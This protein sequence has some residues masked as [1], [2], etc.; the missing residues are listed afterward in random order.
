MAWS[1][2]FAEI[3][4][5]ENKRVNFDTQLWLLIS[6]VNLLFDALQC[7]VINGEAIISLWKRQVSE[8]LQIG[9]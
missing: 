6:L 8:G 3:E 7:A 2:I 9:W 5:R 4:E 1:V